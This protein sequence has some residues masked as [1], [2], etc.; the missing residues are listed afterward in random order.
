MD[1][2]ALTERLIT[3]DTSNV[4]GLRAAAGFIKGWLEAREIDVVDHQF[5]DLHAL[6][7]VVGP[8]EDA[9]R[10]TLVFHGHF[11]V[12]PGRP[13]QFVPRVEGDRLFGR[14]A[15]DMKGA[16]ASMMCALRDLADQDAGA[17][18]L[19]L[20]ARRGVR[21]HRA[22]HERRPRPPRPASATS[23][24]PASRRTCTSG[25]Q[26][27]GVLACRLI[28][29]GRAAHGSTPW[30]GDNAVLKAIDVFRRIESLPFSRESSELFDRP[31]I[32][33]GRIQGGDALNKV[34]D[35]CTMVLDIRYLPNQDPGDILEQIRTI[36][37]MEVARTFI[38]PPAHVSRTNPYVLALADVV[39]RLTSGESMSV[40]RDGASD[41][42]SFLRAGIPAVEFGPA[43]AGHH[44]PE[45]WV[46]ISSL[47]RYRQALTDFVLQLPGRARRSSRRT[48]A[49]PLRAVEGGRA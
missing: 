3:Y 37:D 1:E 39:G 47:G 12:V 19:R 49:A 42:V 43:G 40:G 36:P 28:V 21:G 34:P 6:S 33:L 26:A 16:L 24:S 9:E 13:E 41:A 8:P 18:A 22:P 11:D 44:G 30:L 14:G 23:R 10:P 31:S 32:N 48:R 5:G 46:S 35:E 17:G 27:K 20:R 38:H 45:E 2:R 29:H 25:I 7:A 4:D 15:Y